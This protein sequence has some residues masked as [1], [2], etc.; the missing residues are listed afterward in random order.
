MSF[1]GLKQSM[2]LRLV[3]VGP[4]A[5][6]DIVAEQ[7]GPYGP[8]VIGGIACP[9][10]TSIVWLVVGM[11]SRERAQSEWREKF[12][13]YHGKDGTPPLL[14]QDREAERNGKNLIRANAGVVALLAVNHVVQIATRFV[15]IPTVKGSFCLLGHLAP[16]LRPL[17]KHSPPLSHQAQCV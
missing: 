17:V 4:Q 15:P 11:V 16:F 1:E 5:C 12:V 2:G 7:P 8:L 13:G 3:P 6:V 9:K 10:I 14:S